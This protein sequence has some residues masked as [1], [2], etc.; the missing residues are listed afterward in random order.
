MRRNI[1]FSKV[2]SPD[3]QGE[4]ILTSNYSSKTPKIITYPG[5]EEKHNSNL[6]FFE[7][8]IIFPG[9]YNA[10]WNNSNLK[11]FFKN[12]ITQV[13]RNNSNLKFFQD[14]IISLRNMNE[15]E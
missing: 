8:S 5:S 7:D 12:S 1:N 14:S 4:I 11:L 15:K 10:K 6:K 3:N 2:K 9:S 13:R